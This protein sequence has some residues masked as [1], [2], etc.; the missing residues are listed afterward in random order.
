MFQTHTQK[1]IFY[2]FLWLGGIIALYTL[3]YSFVLEPSSNTTHTQTEVTPKHTKPTSIT[4]NNTMLIQKKP[5]EAT[6]KTMPKQAKT[7][8]IS[9][10]KEEV[11]IQKVDDT[12][13]SRDAQLQEL[14]ALRQKI[15]D[16]AEASR[17]KA[18]QEIRK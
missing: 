6:Q 9:E 1:E 14:E 8:H 18:I 3:L 17:E 10:K 13:D 11:I 7:K 5:L 16:E 12:I 15:I 2:I 4:S